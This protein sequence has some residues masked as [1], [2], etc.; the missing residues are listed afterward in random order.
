MGDDGYHGGAFMLAANFGFY[1]RGFQP[2]TEPQI[3][4]PT[5]PVDFGTI[6]SYRFYLNAGNIANLDKTYLKGGNW[7]FTDQATH[8]TYDAYWQARD[9][10]RHMKN[11]RCAVL[12]VG[13]WYDAEDL[14]GPYRTFNATSK[15]NPET[16]TTLV[17][18]PWVHGGWA[19]GDG[20]HLGDV[21]FNS[22]TS[23]YFRA[24]IQFPFFEHL[25]EGQGR[26]TAEG[27]G[28]RNRNKCMAQ[29]RCVAP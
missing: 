25:P 29:F 7:L 13:G 24:N 12:V 9:L 11:I 20:D 5:V 17:E 26:C 1:G 2:Q 21:Q 14:S 4:K 27:R 15:L 19:R 6:D 23:E 18:G 28:L 3:P 22:K 8:N 10:S 16:P